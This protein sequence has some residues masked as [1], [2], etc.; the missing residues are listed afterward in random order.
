MCGRTIPSS[1][2][3]LSVTTA[4]TFTVASEGVSVC[5]ANNPEISDTVVFSS[6][7]NRELQHF[8]RGAAGLVL[9]LQLP[10]RGVSF[11]ALFSCPL[12]GCCTLWRP[13]T[14]LSCAEQQYCG[15][16]LVHRCSLQRDIYSWGMFLFQP[17]PVPVHPLGSPQHG[18]S[19]SVCPRNAPYAVLQSAV[20]LALLL[21]ICFIWIYIYSQE[22]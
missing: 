18:P 12:R 2:L 9:W 17:T 3:T 8:W 6:E 20:S 11:E 13:Y 7:G 14:Q 5:F 22:L 1:S 4:C 16:R 21:A 10:R 19:R 15:L